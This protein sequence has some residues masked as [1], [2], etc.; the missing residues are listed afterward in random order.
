MQTQ[1]NTAKQT[2]QHRRT[3]FRRGSSSPFNPGFLEK[4]HVDSGIKKGA[5]IATDDVGWNYYFLCLLAY[6][7]SKPL[8]K[9]NIATKVRVAQVQEVGDSILAIATA[10]KESSKSA[11]ATNISMPTLSHLANLKAFIHTASSLPV[12]RAVFSKV[13]KKA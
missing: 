12:F 1:P 6:T 8:A 2:A 11:P 4:R 9:S 7:V 3:V 10:T 5:E 13:R